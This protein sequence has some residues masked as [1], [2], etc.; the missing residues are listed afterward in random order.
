MSPNHHSSFILSTVLAIGSLSTL[1][2][3]ID[4][5]VINMFLGNLSNATERQ[6]RKTKKKVGIN[7][8]MF[9]FIADRKTVDVFHSQHRQIQ[10]MIPMMNWT[11]A[12]NLRSLSFRQEKSQFCTEKKME[13]FHVVHYCRFSLPA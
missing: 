9:I 8:S 2:R 13:I 4:I 12:R 1:Y 5:E 6:A 3:T 11:L 7:H 10:V